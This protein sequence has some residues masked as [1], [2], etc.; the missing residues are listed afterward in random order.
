MPQTAPL[1]RIRPGVNESPVH[2]PNRELN[3]SARKGAGAPSSFCVNVVT[4]NATPAVSWMRA[5]VYHPDGVEKLHPVDLKGTGFCSK[6]TMNAA[7]GNGGGV[8]VGVVDE[9]PPQP[10]SAAQAAV[11]TSAQMARPGVIARW[12]TAR[13]AAS[14]TG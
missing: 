3:D 4:V 11:I 1:A 12:T 13:C 14:R 9:P 6:V 5:D 10:T 8:G 2:A 7:V